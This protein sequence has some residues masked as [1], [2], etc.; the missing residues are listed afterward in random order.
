MSRTGV[1]MDRRGF[2]SWGNVRS[3]GIGIGA[4]GRGDDV[5]VGDGAAAIVVKTGNIL[6]LGCA[7]VFREGRDCREAL[8]LVESRLGGG[9]RRTKGQPEFAIPAV[10]AV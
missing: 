1:A 7:P 3:E 10:D 4:P 8:R 6:F 5:R 2:V 9:M